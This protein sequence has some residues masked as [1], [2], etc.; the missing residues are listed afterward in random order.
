VCG[1]AGFWGDMARRK[2]ADSRLQAMTARLAHRGPDGQSRWLG[3]DAGLGHTR[4]AIIDLAGGAQPMWSACGRYVIV[5][6]GEIYNYPQLREQL[7]GLGYRLQTNSDTE[8]IWAAIDAWGVEQGLLRLRGMFAFALYSTYD[9]TLLL[10]RDRVGIKPLF[11]ARLSGGLA[12]ASEPKALLTLPEVRRRI[13]APGVHD[14][15]ATGYATSPRTCWE[16]IDVLEPGCWLKISPQGERGGRY[17]KWAPRVRQGITLDEATGEVD[18]AL[19]DAVHSHLIADVPVGAFLSGGL[20]SSLIAA[21]LGA[22]TQTFSVGFGD[23][24]YDETRYAR[25]LARDFH[26]DHHEIQI[27]GGGGEP[28][29]LR[30]IVEQFDEPFGDS[31]AI[32]LYLMC[33]EV[34]KGMKV[35]LSGD[36]GDEVLGG[37]PRYLY[38]RKIASLARLNGFLP[39]LQPVASFAEG[40]LGHYGRQAAKAWRFAQLSPPERFSALQSYFVEEQ[41]RRMYQP[42]FAERVAG[43]GS[44]AL[45][46]GR[47][48]PAG[49]EDPTQQMIAAEIALRLHADYLRK[50]DVASSA[51]GL[52]VRV[53]YLDAGMLDL[54]AELPVDFKVARNGE[55][56]I[57]SR[58][59]ARKYLPEGFSSRRKQGFSI[60]LDRWAGPRMREFFQ[61]LLLSSA[62]KSAALLKPVAIRE[63]WDAFDG[64]ATSGGVSRYQRYQRLFLLTSLELWLRRWSPSLP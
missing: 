39:R 4:L 38:A 33:R 10:A 11:L 43:E 55:T 48:V 51:H 13:H 58:R 60:P 59:L 19:R 57:L 52:E 27:A 23:P 12:F 40:R 36:G 17:W 37:Y 15:L 46:L 18:A 42:D 32:P 20:D 54:G 5:F 41:R 56:K 28:D 61:D 26:T 14:Y 64:A 16:D 30:A 7:G 3:G 45:R 44:T 31:S 6:N 2:D 25:E 21:L 50:V 47:F 53:P 62:A 63:V 49:V 9:H 24:E 22:R 35:V 8:V 34:S 1:I 29:L